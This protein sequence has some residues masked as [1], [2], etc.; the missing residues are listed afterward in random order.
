LTGECYAVLVEAR[1]DDEQ[2]CG[3][4]IFEKSRR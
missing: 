3:P 1:K 4:F 2:R